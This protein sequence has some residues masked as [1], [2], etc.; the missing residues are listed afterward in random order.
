MAAG[1][2]ARP[3]RGMVPLMASTLSPYPGA[4]EAIIV[5]EGAPVT[6]RPAT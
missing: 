2:E 4:E 3:N 5:G 6:V 1:D